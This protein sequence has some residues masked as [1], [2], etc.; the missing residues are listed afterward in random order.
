MRIPEVE[1]PSLLIYVSILISGTSFV[2][3][4]D[5]PQ[6]ELTIRSIDANSK[7]NSEQPARVNLTCKFNPIKFNY[8]K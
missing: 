3:A 1:V 5:I 7:S 2:L 8:N 4:G 6:K